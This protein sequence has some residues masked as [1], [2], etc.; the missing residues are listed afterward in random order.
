MHKENWKY[1]NNNIN[2]DDNN[3]NNNFQSHKIYS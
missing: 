2:I 3:E 1:N